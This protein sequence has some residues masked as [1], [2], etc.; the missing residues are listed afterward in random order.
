M[1]TAGLATTPAAQPANA[2]TTTLGSTFTGASNADE[3]GHDTALSQDGTRMIVGAPGDDSA[4]NDAG[5]AQIFDWDGTNW[6]QIGGDLTFGNAGDRFGHAVDITRDGQ[7]VVIGAERKLLRRCGRHLHLGRQR[8]NQ[9][10]GTIDGA[11]TGGEFGTAVAISDDE[12][13]R[14]RCP[15]PTAAAA[16]SR[17]GP[18][19]RPPG[20]NSATSSTARATTTSAL[21]WPSRPTDTSSLSVPPDTAPPARSTSSSGRAAPGKAAPAARTATSKASVPQSTSPPPAATW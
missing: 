11:H 7:T 4:G 20:P 5:L 8:R 17:Y 12:L 19:T 13:D 1:L 2:A 18:G 16:R 10:G 15:R 6:N 9:N 14:R 3:Y 21:R